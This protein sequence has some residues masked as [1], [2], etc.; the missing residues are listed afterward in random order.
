MLLKKQAKMIYIYDNEVNNISKC[1]VLHDIANPPKCAKN[2]NSHWYPILHVCI[3][4]RKGRAKFKISRI[5]LDS[6][7]SSTIV[8]K[9]LVEKLYPE[10]M[11]WFSG[12]HRPETS[13]L[14]LRLNWILPYPH[15]AWLISWHGSVMCMTPLGVGMIWY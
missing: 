14:I 12:K 13:L 4:T 15:L 11:L 3:N 6:G 2:I 1:N 9:S 5:I 8:M 7:C 10:K